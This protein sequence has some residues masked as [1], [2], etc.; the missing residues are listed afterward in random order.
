MLVINDPSDLPRIA[1]PAI[2]ELV[3]LRL[4]QLE[5]QLSPEA[6]NA[7]PYEF[8]VVEV[9]DAVSEIE[10]AAGFTIVTSLFDDLPYTDPDFCPCHE[11]LEK[12]TYGNT[13]IYEMV[14]IGSD[15]GAAT[16][17]LIP[18][19]EGVDADLLALCRAWAVPAMNTQVNTP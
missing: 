7:T 11:L 10:Q 4:Q 3:A 2:Q 6:S 9:G 19:T 5:Q 12:F 14:F 1:N 17:V 13:C 16:C 15:D 8:I 18:D